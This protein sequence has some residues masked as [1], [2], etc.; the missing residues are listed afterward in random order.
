MEGE[1]ITRLE[2]EKRGQQRR[3]LLIL[4]LLGA[5]FGGFVLGMVVGARGPSE[6]PVATAPVP[7]VEPEGASPQVSAANETAPKEVPLTFYERLREPSQEPPAPQ[8]EREEA[9]APV[10]KPSGGLLLQV[11]S[12]KDPQRAENLSRKLSSEGFP[13]EVRKAQVKGGTWYRVL[14]RARDRD[15][16]DRF[17]RSLEAKGFEG[18]RT[19]KED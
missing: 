14:V 10:A 19:V 11:A 7:E 3:L 6:A 1:G 2:K 16:A 5:F 13:S 15:E 4:G 9:R 12:F 17:R 8:E 18:I